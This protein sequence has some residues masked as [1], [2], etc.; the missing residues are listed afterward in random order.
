MSRRLE[1]P[2]RKLPEDVPE[3]SAWSDL[4]RRVVLLDD[5][6]RVALQHQVGGGTGWQRGPGDRRALPQHRAGPRGTEVLEA[7]VRG[8]GAQARAAEQQDLAGGGIAAV[9]GRGQ[10]RRSEEPTSE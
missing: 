6:V 3:S 8:S 1:L 9:T 2:I 5:A 10:Q 7:L 4:L